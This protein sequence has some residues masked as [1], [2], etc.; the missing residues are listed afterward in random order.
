MNLDM[1]RPKSKTKDLLLSITKNCEILF[2]QTHKKAQDTLKFK[3]TQS[4]ENF[5][6]KPPISVE[7]CWMIALTSLDKYNSVFII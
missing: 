2:I 5:S 3:L 4:K 6:Y 7:R 1:I